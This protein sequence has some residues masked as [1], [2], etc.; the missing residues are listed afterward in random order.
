MALQLITLHLANDFINMLLA[1][2]DLQFDVTR[3]LAHA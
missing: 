2:S 3:F 1:L